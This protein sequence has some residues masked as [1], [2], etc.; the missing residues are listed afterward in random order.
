LKSEIFSAYG[1]PMPIS[2]EMHYVKISLPYSRMIPSYLETY[3]LTA[4]R[5][6]LI[7]SIVAAS[8]LF[9]DLRAGSRRIRQPH[10]PAAPGFAS[11]GFFILA[12]LPAPSERRPH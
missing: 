2:V 4:I 9:P 1:T 7:A 5:G 10:P 12:F 3:H 11:G 6:L 8:P